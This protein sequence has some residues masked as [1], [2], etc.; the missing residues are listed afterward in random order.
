MPYEHNE[1]IKAQY[2]RL[3]ADRARAIGEYEASRLSDDSDNT[4]AWADNIVSIDAKLAALGNIAR[5]A[6]AGPRMPQARMPGRRVE[7]AD[8]HGD[9][10]VVQLTDEEV[11]IARRSLVD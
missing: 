8:E 9:K 7:I 6:N 5:Q 2:E 11:D 10:H 3:A 4:M 1:V